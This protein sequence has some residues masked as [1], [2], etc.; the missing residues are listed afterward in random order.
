MAN[1]G[2]ILIADG[3]SV[4]VSLLCSMFEDGFEVLCAKSGEDALNSIASFRPDVVLLGNVAG[5]MS[6]RDVC[7]RLKADHGTAS[8]PVLFITPADNAGAE[9]ACLAAGGTDCLTKPFRPAVVRARVCSYIELRRARENI[10]LLSTA[11]PL[12][13][14]YNRR[15]F[16]RMLI[17]EV[18]RASRSRDCLSL[19]MLDVDRFKAYNDCNGHLAGDE[20]LKLVCRTVKKNF[21]RLG[22]IVARYGGEELAVLLPSTG[23]EPAR[24]LAEGFVTISAGVASMAPG[25]DSDPRSLLDDADKALYQA[26]TKGRNCVVGG[27]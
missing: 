13:G 2:R 10:E 17:A 6:G 20:C 9:E 25:A 12:T 27:K 8:I 5:S 7:A 21:R 23:A 24:M 15:H 3:D 11:D 4:G 26:K 22:D 16:D 18:R 14:L 1:D 19:I